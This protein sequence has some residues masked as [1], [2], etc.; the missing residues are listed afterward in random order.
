ME[1]DFPMGVARIRVNPTHGVDGTCWSA[2]PITVNNIDYGFPGG[3]Q[4][5]NMFSFSVDEGGRAFKVKWSVVHS[6][7]RWFAPAMRPA[8]DG[9][10]TFKNEGDSQAVTYDGDCF[11][12]VEA[13]R[14]GSDGVISSLA[15]IR[16][17]GPMY[18]LAYAPNCY[19]TTTGS[20]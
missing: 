12:S 18:G 4:T 10:L 7:R 17:Q 3:D 2:W 20:F 13:Y 9:T 6:D 15:L 1:I 19:L 8:F 11:P 5:K 16:S 14:F